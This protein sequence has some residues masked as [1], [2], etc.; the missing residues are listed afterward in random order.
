[1]GSIPLYKVNTEPSE[2]APKRLKLA[3]S[4]E[5]SESDNQAEA[6]DTKVS[7][8]QKKVSNTIKNT[9][10]AVKTFQEWK[11]DRN[12]SFPEDPVPFD[13]LDQK[14]DQRDVAPLIHWLSKFLV[15]ARNK[16]GRMY[17]PTSLHAL[18]CGLLRHMREKNPY[19]PNFMDRYDPRFK[20]LHVLMN[21]TFA[22]LREQGVRTHRKILPSITLEKE[23]ELWERRILGSDS[24]IS[25]QRTVYYMISKM[26]YIKGGLE[27]RA[28]KPSQFTR[29]RNPDCYTF[30]DVGSK[31]NSHHLR[32]VYADL[33]AGNRCFV[34]LFDLFLSKLPP[35]AF[36]KDI[37]YLRPKSNFLPK[38]NSSPW[39]EA[40]PVGKEKLRTM[41]R[42]MF[43]DGGILMG[44]EVTH[45]RSNSQ[46]TSPIEVV[47]QPSTEPLKLH[48]Q[49]HYH[50]VLTSAGQDQSEVCVVPLVSGASIPIVKAITGHQAVQLELVQPVH[51]TSSQPDSICPAS[52]QPSIVCQTTSAVHQ[53]SILGPMTGHSMQSSA[54]QMINQPNAVHQVSIQP[55]EVSHQL[56]NQLS[57][58]HQVSVQPSTVQQVSIIPSGAISCGHPRSLQSNVI[59]QRPILPKSGH[60]ISNNGQQV[61]PLR[62]SI[63]PSQTPVQPGLSS[64]TGT[65]MPKLN[66]C[67]SREHYEMISKIVSAIEMSDDQ[68]LHCVYVCVHKSKSKRR[69]VKGGRA[70]AAEAPF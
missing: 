35:Y 43:V 29:E 44:T 54:V 36:E 16:E 17:S 58:I 1:M 65:G 47:I 41:T 48:Q 39:Y 21:K 5:S 6:V 55:S 25:L 46:V 19:T 66:N 9:A 18:L 53:R 8:K 10:W 45:S 22:N 33:S 20:E 70:H 40:F 42:D 51:Q 24:P 27:H 34:Y 15:E 67:P 60:L 61:S 23:N 3:E 69:W 62:P 31:T 56:S 11:Q 13:I 14:H 30:F 2:P 64:K 52:I 12:E 63:T 4:Y 50:P 28:L 38:E 26:F 7:E 32:K 59:H 68:D 49:L 37:L 57:T